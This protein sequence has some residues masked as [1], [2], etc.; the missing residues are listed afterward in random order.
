MVHMLL[1]LRMTALH[2]EGYDPWWQRPAH[3]G[4][5]ELQSTSQTRNNLG[6]PQIMHYS[7][8][9]AD[10]QEAGWRPLLGHYPQF[11]QPWVDVM[12]PVHAG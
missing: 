4:H 8:E 5:P 11:T 3:A 1:W 2:H 6:H 9:P 12:L 7:T 10:P